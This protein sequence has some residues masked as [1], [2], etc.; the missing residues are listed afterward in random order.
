MLLQ[1]LPIS[2]VT[3]AAT[4]FLHLTEKVFTQL[5]FLF[6]AFT[7]CPM[8]LEMNQDLVF[9]SFMKH[10]AK[11]TSSLHIAESNGLFSVLTY[12]NY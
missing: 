12:L 4:P 11:V 7:L 8:S 1:A 6:I 9:T 3:P 10:T 5:F 2:K